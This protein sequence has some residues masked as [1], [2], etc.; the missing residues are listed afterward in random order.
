MSSTY[1][2]VLADRRVQSITWAGETY[3]P[4][5]EHDAE[6][7]FFVLPA[8][9]ASAVTRIIVDPAS[10]RNGA[11]ETGYRVGDTHPEHHSIGDSHTKD[12]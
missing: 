8:D 10:Q 2:R 9:A 4:I 3:H 11:N 7:H 12:A 6:T 1:V 5:S